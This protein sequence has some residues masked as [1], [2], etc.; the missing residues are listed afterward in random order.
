MSFPRKELARPRSL[1]GLGVPA[2]PISGWLQN[3]RA[4]RCFAF[5]HFFFFFLTSENPVRISFD[6][7]KQVLNADVLEKWNV[8]KRPFKERGIP[9]YTDGIHTPRKA[10]FEGV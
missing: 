8:V 7:C 5:H 4:E 1:L 3:R 2:A 9:V 6:A 10:A